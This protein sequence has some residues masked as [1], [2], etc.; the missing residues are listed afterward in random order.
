VI[1]ELRHRAEE[2]VRERGNEMPELA[3]A[4]SPEES[5]PVLHDLRVHQIELEMQNEELR[6][7]QA[8]LEAS[9]ARYFD[10]YDLAPVGYFTISEQGLILEANFTAATLLGAARGALVQQHLTRFIVPEDQDRYY[11]HR[12][13]L[14]TTGARQVLDLRLQKKDGTQLWARF[15]ATRTPDAEGAGEVCRVVV[16]DISEVKRLEQ[17][18][19]R[20]EHELRQT[21]KA[22]S[23][24]RM[25]GAIAHHFN[26]QLGVVMGNLELSIAEPRVDT[27]TLGDALLAARKAAEV[28]GLLLTYLGQSVGDHAP[29]D[30]SETCRRS[31]PMLRAVMPEDVAL[32]TTLPA[33]GPAVN[34]NANQLQ[35]MVTNLVTNAWEAGGGRRTPIRL[36]VTTVSAAEIPASHRFA[37]GWQPRDQIYACLEVT[38]SGHGISDQEI[39]KIFEPFFT[40]R[41]AGR[42]LGLPVALGIVH[43]HSGGLVVESKRG[44]GSGSAFR[45]YLPLSAETVARPPDASARAP[46]RDAIQWSGT[47]LLVEDEELLRRTTAKTLA[48]LGFTVLDAANG[49]EAVELF[50]RHKD[51]IRFVLCDLTMPH[52]SGWDTLAALRTLAPDVPVI[53]TSGYDEAHV[54]ADGYDERPQGFLGKPYG[55]ADLRDAIRHALDTREI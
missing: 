55:I 9:R 31:L 35:L 17:E 34:A 25:A 39:E 14:L 6:R 45:V 30:L 15:E 12:K 7:T 5:R 22:E 44:R 21:Q 13:R 18:R 40:T 43:A 2:R 38:D 1:D 36:T 4:L 11:L 48:R 23:L 19:Q 24:A 51:V 28:S 8:E 50:P 29:L 46:E 26:N 16:S 37:S 10:L 54:M 49:T 20:F 32:E 42:G 52:M 47:A 41:F 53:L 33:P 27:T 3:R